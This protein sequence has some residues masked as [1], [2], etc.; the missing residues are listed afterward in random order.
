[1]SFRL[2]Y[3]LVSGRLLVDGN[4]FY[5]GNS[6]QNLSQLALKTDIPTV[7]QYV[8]PTEKQCSWN[9]DLSNY[10]TK[11]EVDEKVSS[12]SGMSL[13]YQLSDFSFSFSR[14]SDDSIEVIPGSVVQSFFD[15]NFIAIS[16]EINLRNISNSITNSSRYISLETYGTD[17]YIYARSFFNYSP[18]TASDEF[19][20]SGHMVY[21]PSSS[22][23]MF[24]EGDN[25]TSR[26]LVYGVPL[27][28]VREDYRLT[29]NGTLS[30]SIYGI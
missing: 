4:N 23:H 28:L 6:S 11:S 24:R 15:C 10:Y 21:S 5:I 1:M 22:E 26:F 30:L 3:P 14:D 27:E 16:G 7:S 20:I 9:P 8:H 13:I 2:E 12:N 29:C 25:I 19:S 18:S 17:N